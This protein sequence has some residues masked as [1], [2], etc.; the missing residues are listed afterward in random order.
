MIL[1]S[2][3]QKIHRPLHVFFV[4]QKNM[5]ILHHFG[6]SGSKDPF[7]FAICV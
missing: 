7:T 6:L 3:V 1:A 4:W 2:L 5:Q